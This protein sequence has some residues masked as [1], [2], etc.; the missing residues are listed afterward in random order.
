MT[1]GQKRSP[2]DKES[3]CIR[4]I[5]R[6]L[7]TK[8]HWPSQLQ[9]ISPQPAF[10]RK[11]S[12]PNWLHKVVELADIFSAKKR[13]EI[14]SR[15]KSS[16]T[17]VEKVLYSLVRE[18]VGSRWRIERNSR[19]LPG[20]P[21]IVIPRLRVAIFADGCFYHGC[22]S[23]GHIPKSNLQYWLPKLARTK[24]RDKANRRELRRMGFAVW[25]FWEHSLEGKVLQRTGLTIQKRLCRLMRD[26]GIA[27]GVNCR[28]RPKSRLRKKL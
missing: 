7:S 24:R 27:S 14:M 28:F 9:Q 8:S 13:S 10:T 22:S 26:R 16:G 20:Q 21:D 19:K 15:I 5:L 23:H 6:L 3:L 4:E 17:I 1:W 25:R 11:Q 2:A 12:K 18:S